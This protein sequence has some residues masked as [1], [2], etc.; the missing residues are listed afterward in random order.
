MKQ[1]NFERNAVLWWSE[2]EE[3]QQIKELKKKIAYLLW[4]SSSDQNTNKSLKNCEKKKKR[5]D[6]RQLLQNIINTN[7]HYSHPYLSSDK[8]KDEKK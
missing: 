5:C 4:P 8:K 6:L 1:Y 3:I 7:L 2:L